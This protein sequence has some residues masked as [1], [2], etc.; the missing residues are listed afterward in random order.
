MKL[1]R[2]IVV[3]AGLAVLPAA[4]AAPAVVE[5]QGRE[6]IV[7]LYLVSVAA[8]RCGFAMTAKQVDA[9]DREVKA[10]AQRMNLSEDQNDVL[11]SE[12]DMAFEKQGPKVCDRDGSFA[13]M[14]KEILQK[15]TGQ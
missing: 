2:Y 1:V 13:K 15:L 6:N 7:N 4:A 10:L 9:V 3:G 8:D 14:Y 12:A 11:Y 5:K